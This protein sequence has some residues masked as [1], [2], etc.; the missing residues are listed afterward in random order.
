MTDEHN[1]SFEKVLSVSVINVIEDIDEDGIEDQFDSDDDGDG[2]PDESDPDR[3]GD[4]L[5]NAEEIAN[6]SNPLDPN[7]VNYPANSISSVDGLKIVENSAIGSLV[8]QLLAID[9]DDGAT[10]QY[11]LVDNN[12]Y[13]ANQLF[14]LSEEG[15]LRTETI[16]NYEANSS[17]YEIRVKASDEYNASSVHTLTVELV[18]DIMIS[19]YSLD[20]NP[21][22]WLDA[23]D[24]SLMDTGFELADNI[25]SNGEEVGFWKDKSGKGYD[26]I[27]INHLN[28]DGRLPVYR[29]SGFTDQNLPYLHFTNDCMI[30]EGSE[31]SFDSWNELSVFAV[32]KTSLTSWDVNFGKIINNFENSWSFYSNRPDLTPPQF[33]FKVGGTTANDTL[34]LHTEILNDFGILQLKLG[35]GKGVYFNGEQLGSFTDSG[36]ITALEDTPVTIGSDAKFL[37][38]L[39][40][41]LKLGEFLIFNKLLTESNRH[42]LEG[43]LGHKWDFI[44][45]F[46]ATH[47]HYNIFPVDQSFVMAENMSVGSSLGTLSSTLA[48]YDSSL[49]YSLAESNSTN[50]NQYFT[51]SSTGILKNAQLFDYES[52]QSEYTIGFV[53]KN[54]DGAMVSTINQTVYLIN[55]VED[56]DE[57]GIEDAYDPDDDDDGFSDISEIAYGSNPKD[58]QSVANASPTDISSPVSLSINE[59]AP[60]GAEVGRLIVSDDDTNDSY[61]FDVLHPYPEDL[62]PAIWYDPTDNTKITFPLVP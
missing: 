25:P 15:Y 32:L 52:N 24:S 53:A 17:S 16:F 34:N 9:P 36:S 29:S 56:F 41:N 12:S 26:A 27:G 61:R 44:H 1:A 8:G 31:E 40:A 50:D 42:K 49:D 33:A 51:L 48:N 13:P 43:Y 62:N 7:S 54:G 3:D 45:E 4:G 60:I 57:D 21:M 58:D 10:H 20:I 22:L 30:I 23:T 39:S 28:Y 6:G 35:G 2:I 5:S 47:P 59:N 14:S 11:Q 37:P 46:P 55:E 19:P 18:D 38:T